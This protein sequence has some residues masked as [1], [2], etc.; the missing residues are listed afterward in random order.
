M[1][2]LAAG[3]AGARADRVRRQRQTSATLNLSNHAA[4]WWYK[5]TTTGKTTCTA[6]AANTASTKVTGLTP[7]TAYT[8]TAYRDSG[9]ATSLAAASAFTTGGV[10]VS[11]LGESGTSPSLFSPTR[12]W[13][14]A[15]TTGP[16]SSGYTLHSAALPLTKNAAATVTLTVH[17]GKTSGNNVVPSDTVVTTLTTG[18][19]HEDTITDVINACTESCTL[20]KNTP[21]FVVATVT[22][23]GGQATWTY[24]SSFDETLVPSGS[25][26]GR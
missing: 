6:V 9:C 19:I 11:N 5:S 25:T 20:Q 21:Y 3:N 23:N 18:A 10:S 26:A 12:R 14:T 15:F 17:T 2:E 24:T 13:A 7:L 8:F 4:A 16:N 1:G 22:G